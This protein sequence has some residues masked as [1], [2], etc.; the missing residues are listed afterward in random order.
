MRETALPGLKNLSK[1]AT[2]ISAT[3]RLVRNIF[4]QAIRRM[5]VRIVDKVPSD[6]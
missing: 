5:A 1:P 6:A 3:A 4:E 2:N